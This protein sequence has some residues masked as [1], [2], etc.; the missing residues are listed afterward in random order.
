M[1]CI[2]CE[3]LVDE[4]RG[5]YFTR[6]LWSPQ[7]NAYVRVRYHAKC[8]DRANLVREIGL[9]A[10]Y[11]RLVDYGDSPRRLEDWPT[12]CGKYVIGDTESIY[13]SKK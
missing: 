4:E 11:Q 10:M 2:V 9:A 7:H 3:C 12:F 6:I 8:K 1:Y 5:H 13:I